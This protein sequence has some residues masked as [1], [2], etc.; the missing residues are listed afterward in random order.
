MNYIHD[1][2]KR[3]DRAREVANHAALNGMKQLFVKTLEPDAVPPHAVCDVAF[4]NSNQLVNIQNDITTNA[5]ELK[6][7]FS[8]TGDSLSSQVQVTKIIAKP[9]PQSLRLQ[10]EPIGDYSTYTLSVTYKNNIDPIFANIDFKFR[11]GC[12]NMN[13]APDWESSPAPQIEPVID[14]QAKDF[15]SFKHVLINAMSARVPDWAPTS[16]A[17]LD[18]VLIDLISA[19]AD[20]LSDF[21]DRVMNEAYLNSARKRVSLARHARLMDYHIH[22]GNQASTWLAI[23]VNLDVELKPWYEPQGFGVWTGNTTAAIQAV[24]DP[25]AVI[26]GF[27]GKTNEPGRAKK[28]PDEDVVNDSKKCF[29]LL[30]EIKPYT[31]EDLTTALEV[32]A[33]QADLA[34]PAGLNATDENDANQLR[35][36]FRDEGVSHILL[37]QKLN[38][39]TATTNGRDVGAR[40]IMQLL[41]DNNAAE[42]VFDPKAAQWFVRIYW[43]EQDKLN[44]R[45]CF[46]TKSTELGDKD[47]VSLFY[48]NLIY[49]AQGR[50]HKTTFTEPVTVLA[51]TVTNQLLHED[52]AYFESTYIIDKKDGPVWGSLCRL[53][54]SPLAY[55]ATSST[56]DTLTQSRF[57]ENPQWG[58]Q[59]I[60]S[61]LRIK[62]DNKTWYEHSDLIES[63]SN[64]T[65]FIVETDEYDISQ[66]RFGNNR[67]GQALKKDANIVCLYQVGQGNRGNVGADKLIG[68][69]SS[70]YPE[71]TAT[72]N[73]LDVTNG[74]SAEPPDQIIRRVPEA[75]RSRQLRAVTLEDY[76]ARAEEL[77]MVDHAAAGYVWTGSWRA[78][79]VVIDPKDATDVSDQLRV[80]IS[81]YLDTVRLIGDDIEIRPARYV[82]LDIEL[83]LCVHPDYWPEDIDAVLQVEFSDGYTSDGR[84]GF[85]HPDLWTFGQ[86]LYV[87]QIT[88]RA[89]SVT[90]VERLL[91]IKIRRLSPNAGASL[92]TV[93]IKPEDLPFTHQDKVEVDQ[94]EIIQVENDPGRLAT[95]RIEFD[96][97]GG[98]A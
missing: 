88:G 49:V 92:N 11:P 45:Y 85:F 54:N 80:K 27:V 24:A 63:E 82:P 16:E 97:V 37:E 10:I 3:R 39:E 84:P 19:D 21:Q 6:D 52:S 22:P 17:D 41:D 90:G 65:H 78:V 51:T 62:V 31:W 64:D 87:S 86:S 70:T 83:H 26:F 91:E 30:N 66:I 9:T 33:T 38:P 57:P 95:G 29:A 68:F 25:E 56:G 4:L 7:I 75:Y 46:I 14:Y 61:T 55:L 34:L 18:Q 8:I 32:G 15:D 2:E 74:R 67:N 94:F 20:E 59:W 36:L 79:Q 81:R 93:I 13:C 98:R 60:Q 72:W 71:I 50:P 58:E 5:L 48:G 73:P 77:D 12:F 53:S 23:K 96:I 43:H 42:S 76:V 35:D 44:R 1:K 69:D 47:E 40:Q 28:I 89:L